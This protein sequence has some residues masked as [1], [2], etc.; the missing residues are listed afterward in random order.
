MEK[1]EKKERKK[2]EKEEKSVRGRI[3]TCD[4]LLVK[5]T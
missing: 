4:L 2:R 1:E 3:R 5:A